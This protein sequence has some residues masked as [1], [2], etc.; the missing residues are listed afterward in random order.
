MIIST[1]TGRP[2]DDPYDLPF[3]GF[4]VSEALPACV[5][6][7]SLIKCLTLAS[8][9][10]VGKCIYGRARGLESVPVYG[11]VLV[12]DSMLTRPIADSS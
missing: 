5:R 11:L 9:S 3:W 10:F 6:R 12:E 1:P 2:V 7:T 8:T 4:E